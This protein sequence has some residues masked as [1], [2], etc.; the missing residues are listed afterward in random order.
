MRD[1]FIGFAA[2]SRG[3][4]AQAVSYQSERATPIVIFVCA[5]RAGIFDLHARGARC[6]LTRSVHG[7]L[8]E[9][10]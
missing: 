2:P 8:G 7:T 5:R 9:R 6:D 1:E 10:Y 3:M 4:W